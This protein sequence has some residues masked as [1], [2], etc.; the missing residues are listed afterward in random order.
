MIKLGSIK[1]KKSLLEFVALGTWSEKTRSL[2]TNWIIYV[3]EL[4]LQLV[5][6]EV[7]FYKLL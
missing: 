2:F 5:G 1:S 7:D 6:Q 4:F 3:T